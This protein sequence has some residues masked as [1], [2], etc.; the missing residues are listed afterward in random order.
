MSAADND[1][2]SPSFANT[3]APSPGTVLAYLWP[4]KGPSSPRTYPTLRKQRVVL[5]RQSCRTGTGA[6]H[7]DDVD[8]PGAMGGARRQVGYRRDCEPS[9]EVN[10]TVI[11]PD[12]SIRGLLL[13]EIEPDSVRRWALRIHRLCLVTF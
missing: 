6:V 13:P 10:Q 2:P 8:A 5:S 12:R 11:G 4:S 1:E 3:F 9:R 7:A